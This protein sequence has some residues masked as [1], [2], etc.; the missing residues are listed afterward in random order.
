ME[1]SAYAPTLDDAALL[2]RYAGAA[3][4]A[5]FSELVRRYAGMVYATA[6]R[7]TGDPSAAEDVS[8]DCFLRLAR[9]SSGI[10]GSLPAWLH[11]TSLNRSLELVRSDRA[12]RRREAD[13]A[14]AR[15]DAGDR[16]ESARL[17]A[18]VD[19]AMGQLPEDR[20]RLKSNVR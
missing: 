9:S 19:E 12:R 18:H 6:R 16:E 20:P 1:P 10:E 8:Q 3:D 15:A 2:R 11:R 14:A 17:I 5:A 4:A 7:V 13:S